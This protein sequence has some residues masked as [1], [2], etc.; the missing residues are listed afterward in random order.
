METLSPAQVSAFNAVRDRLSAAERAVVDIASVE[1]VYPAKA[2]ASHWNFD[3]PC[4]AADAALGE[5]ATDAQRR[6]LIATWVLELP[7]RVNEADLPPEV[8]QFYP[9]RLDKL[10][11]F[12]SGA[13]ET[14]VAYDRDHWARTCAS[15]WFS[16]C[17]APRPRPSACRRRWGQVR[18]SA[19]VATATAGAS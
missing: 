19:T 3:L 16:A 1:A 17:R 13:A 15:L 11:A 4:H 14:G 5:G 2:S 12:L 9:F 8:L 6:A 18:W 10:A 7:G